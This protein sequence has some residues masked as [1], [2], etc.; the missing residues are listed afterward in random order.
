MNITTHL[1]T[2]DHHYCECFIFYLPSETNVCIVHL[3]TVI[4]TFVLTYELPSPEAALPYLFFLHKLT[5]FKQVFFFK[6]R[7]R[8]IC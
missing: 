8:L 3:T 7:N 1:T 5:E 6:K 4:C 2:R